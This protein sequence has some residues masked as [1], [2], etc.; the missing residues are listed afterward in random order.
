MASQFLHLMETESLS[1]PVAQAGSPQIVEGANFD[2]G[3]PP[4]QV[5]GQGKRSTLSV[6]D[7]PL[8]CGL[9][10]LLRGDID[11]HVREVNVS[12]SGVHEFTTSHAGTQSHTNQHF[13]FD[14]RSFLFALSGGPTQAATLV[15]TEHAN[16]ALRSLGRREP[17]QR[18]PIE[19]PA[20]FGKL[21]TPS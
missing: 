8:P 11:R 18:M 17:T 1:D 15:I 5:S 9:A 16:L 19:L 13:P 3:Q 4:H 20:I 14:G 7:V 2:A 21:K 10:V 6:L 12:P